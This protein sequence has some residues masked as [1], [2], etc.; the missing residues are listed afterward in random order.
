MPLGKST[1]PDN[2]PITHRM[3][4]ERIQERGGGG[5]EKRGEEKPDKGENVIWQIKI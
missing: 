5:E 4:A 1:I 3:E 2:N